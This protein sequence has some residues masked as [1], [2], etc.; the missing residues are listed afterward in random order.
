MKQ[1]LFKVK[2][3]K[4]FDFLFMGIIIMMALTSFLALYTA[5]PLIARNGGPDIL[6]RQMQWYIIGFAA[7]GILMYLGDD[8]IY[9]AA[10]VLY[11]FLLIALLYL[12]INK[13]IINRFLGSSYNLPFVLRVNGATS[14]FS[15]SGIGS[16]QPSEFMKVVL[17]I[18]SA[19]I[20]NEHN[21]EK[22]I[23][24]FQSD[25]ELFI[26]I[27]KWALPP[28]LMI[29][30]QPDTGV[31][32]II[33]VS[34]LVMLMC[35]GI[36]REWIFLIAAVGIGILVI[37]FYLYFFHFSFLSSLF[38]NNGAY[39][40]SRIT[41]WLN[42]ESDILNT[43]N[44]S[45]TAMMALGSAGLFGLGLQPDIGLHIP[46]AQ[47][48]FIFAVFGNGFGL[49]GSL[50]ILGLCLALDL[51]LIS[52]ATLSKNNFEKY[53]ICGILGMLLFQQFENIGMIIGLL[54]ITGIT[55]PLI[56]YGGSSLLSY[57]LAFGIVMNASVKA[58]KGSE[59]IYKKGF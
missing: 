33:G 29:L 5:F 18:I 10:K 34:L 11:W 38:G 36:K 39:K 2:E 37:F 12:L 1:K 24:T 48:D 52:I 13:E 19:G 42:P 46:E 58:K 50:L 45:Y 44:Q 7:M 25:I 9:T 22:M 20:I 6:M 28:M 15:F 51:R 32:I 21:A 30:M 16:F 55:L 54:P 26:K 49:I 40:L 43:G 53:Y 14:W 57:M 56:S 27:A 8:S 3:S 31:V 23:D 35:S 17:I 41:S 47:T 59:Y 4:R